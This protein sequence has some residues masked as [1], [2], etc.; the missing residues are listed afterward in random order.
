MAVPFLRGRKRG[1]KKR[2]L[3]K[4]SSSHLTCFPNAKIEVITHTSPENAY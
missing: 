3:I 1:M 2:V 4:K